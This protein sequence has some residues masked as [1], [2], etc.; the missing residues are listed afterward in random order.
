MTYM[1]KKSTMLPFVLSGAEGQAK[2][3]LCVDHIALEC[4]ERK[5]KPYITYSRMLKYTEYI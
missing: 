4:S 1:K 5:Q 2:D 3:A